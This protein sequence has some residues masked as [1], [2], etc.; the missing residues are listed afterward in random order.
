MSTEKYYMLHKITFR[1]AILYVSCDFYVLFSST[2]L[3]FS[4]EFQQHSLPFTGRLSGI[5][6]GLIAR[7]GSAYDHDILVRFQVVEALK[8]IRLKVFPRPSLK[9]N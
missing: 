3:L 5:D 9:F 6:E 7:K 4:K 2:T 8:F 1:L